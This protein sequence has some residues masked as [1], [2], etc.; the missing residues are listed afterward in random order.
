MSTLAVICKDLF[1][2]IHV[3]AH[4][5]GYLHLWH[6]LPNIFSSLCVH[7]MGAK[8]FVGAVFLFPKIN[9]L[10]FQCVLNDLGYFT[11]I[12]VLCLSCVRLHDLKKWGIV[13]ISLSLH[14]NKNSSSSETWGFFTRISIYLETPLDQY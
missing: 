9:L 5:D 4:L 7:H 8:G 1:V 2:V 13:Y 11:N 6:G 10:Y 12:G 14:I 3:G